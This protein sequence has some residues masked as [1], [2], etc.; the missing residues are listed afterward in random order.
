QLW[1]KASR[2]SGH[3][4]LPV[5]LAI[6]ECDERTSA[7]MPQRLARLTEETE[8]PDALDSQFRGHDVPARDGR[9][10]ESCQQMVTCA[11]RG[12]RV[13]RNDVRQNRFVEARIAGQVERGVAKEILRMAAP[14]SQFQRDAMWP[15]LP[16]PHP[17]RNVPQELAQ[18]R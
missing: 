15:M 10:L 2:L 4:N 7:L 1:V 9:A 11:A 13:V 16:G 8:M 12:M 18:C 17:A 6:G 14:A 3:R 5:A